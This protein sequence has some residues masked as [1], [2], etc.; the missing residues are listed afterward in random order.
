MISDLVLSSTH[1]SLS[2]QVDFIPERASVV[3]MQGEERQVT[4]AEIR[5]DDFVLVRTGERIPIDG[6]VLRGEGIVDD[7]V[8]TGDSEPAPVVKNAK[9]LAGSLYTGSLLLLRAT[10]KFEDC[11][12][13][14]IMRVPVSYTH[15]DCD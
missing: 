6:I 8:L 7:T 3:N 10:A 12:V 5:V 15:L 2:Q 4:P 14:Q 1:K 11:A 9:V 13:S